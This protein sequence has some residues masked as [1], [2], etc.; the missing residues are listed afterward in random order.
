[1]IRYYNIKFEK[2]N[3]TPKLLLC[4]FNNYSKN[5]VF[6][7]ALKTYNDPLNQRDLIRKE[8]N[9]KIGVYS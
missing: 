9:G 8:N 5:I 3:F 2:K 7:H 6:E 1:M 4:N